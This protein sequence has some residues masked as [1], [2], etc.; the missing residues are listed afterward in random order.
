M[1]KIKIL[2]FSISKKMLSM[3]LAFFPQKP[4]TWIKSQHCAFIVQFLN[5]IHPGI[6]LLSSSFLLITSYSPLSLFYPIL[7]S[8]LSFSFCPCYFS[9]W[10]PIICL[11]FFIFP[12]SFPFFLHCCCYSFLYDKMQWFFHNGRPSCDVMK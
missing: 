10:M 7:P 3:W 6:H 2:G 12:Y 4:K 11:F 5:T 8:F 1:N 9:L